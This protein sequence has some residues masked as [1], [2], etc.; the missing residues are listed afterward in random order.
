MH[1]PIG[2]VIMLPVIVWFFA[3]G[4]YLSFLHLFVDVP[5]VHI[6]SA[7]T[8]WFGLFR[9]ILS[10]ICCAYLESTYVHRRV[11]ACRCTL[12]PA[13]ARPPRPWMHV[14]MKFDI[15][16]GFGNKR[17]RMR[18]RYHIK[19]MRKA[20]FSIATCFRFFVICMALPTKRWRYRWTWMP[21]CA[22]FSCY[23]GNLRQFHQHRHH[24]RNSYINNFNN[25]NNNNNFNNN[26]AQGSVPGCWRWGEVPRANCAEYRRGGR[27][28]FRYALGV[29]HNLDTMLRSPTW[30]HK[31]HK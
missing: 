22:Y 18:I 17:E 21:F 15:F 23:I 5:H 2:L 29:T 26:N 20:F 7:R 30:P 25:N 4:K 6:S 11:I 9:Y 16:V 27:R 8:C 1:C 3:L 28:A 13:C 24:Q 31:A 14:D 10:T 19:S 12:L